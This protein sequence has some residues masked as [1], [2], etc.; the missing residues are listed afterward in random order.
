[1]SRRRKHEASKKS[2]KRSKEQSLNASRNN[3]MRESLPSNFSQSSLDNILLKQCNI[4]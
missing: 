2:H 3:E 1:V 4:D